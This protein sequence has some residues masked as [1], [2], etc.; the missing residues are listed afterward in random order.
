MDKS[1]SEIYNK[2]Q[3]Q[4]WKNLWF[5][6]KK[7]IISAVVAVCIVIFGAVKCSNIERPD[8]GILIVTKYGMNDEVRARAEEKY[9]AY[10]QDVNGDG[11][12]V[13][14]LVVV[15]AGEGNEGEINAGNVSRLN[16]EM[17]RG[18]CNLIVAEKALVEQFLVYDE[19]FEVPVLGKYPA[20]QSESGKAV[21]ADISNSRFAGDI[22]YDKSDTLLLLL[23]GAEEDTPE[24]AMYEQC[25]KVAEII[26][27]N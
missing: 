6:N 21:A 12:N 14:R 27:A 7:I 24:F 18:E 5:Y 11:K 25:L 3:K 8:A 16:T 20:V 22:Y 9:S 19:F 23:K 15:A 2:K 10:V 26:T 17:L 1:Y 4:F 13:V